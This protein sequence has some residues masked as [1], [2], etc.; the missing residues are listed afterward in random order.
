MDPASPRRR[1]FLIPLG[2]AGGLLLGIAARAWMRLISTEPEFSWNGTMFIVLGFTLWGTGQAVAATVR[3]ASDR[4]WAVAAAR[5]SAGILTLPLFVAAGG[6]MFPTVVAGGLASHRT[7]WRSRTRWIFGIVAM[8]PFVMVGLQLHDDWG[9]SW[10][11]LAGMVGLLAVYGV[12]VACE[13]PAMS[14][15]RGSRRASTRRIATAIT[16]AGIAVVVAFAGLRP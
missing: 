10:R 5:T 4:R 12:V 13:R 15:G 3:S 2:A 14:P 7:D 6:I 16:V 1:F 8:G 9:W 11:W